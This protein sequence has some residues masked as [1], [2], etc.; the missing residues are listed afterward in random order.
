MA[1]E[2]IHEF[3]DECEAWPAGTHKDQVDAAA[4]A[5]N[6]LAAGSGYDTTYKAFDPNHR[7]T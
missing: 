7:D 6:R 2:W 3:L 4:G 5:F 1:G